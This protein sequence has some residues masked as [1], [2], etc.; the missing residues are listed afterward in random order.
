[1]INEK[2]NPFKE[3]ES[4]LHEAPIHMKKKVM[5]DIA[6]AKLVLDMST[7]FTSNY[8]SVIEQTFKTKS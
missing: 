1:M 6:S 7:L 4:K 3:M 5:S 8:K 2:R